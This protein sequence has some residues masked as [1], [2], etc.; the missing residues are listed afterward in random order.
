LFLAGHDFGEG[1][2][3]VIIDGNVNVFPADAA[4]VALLAPVVGDAVTDPVEPAQLFDVDV[5]HLTRALAFVAPRRLRW[6]ARRRPGEPQPP[7]HPAD[8]GFRDPNGGRDLLAG[9]ALPAQVRHR[10]AL[11]SGSLARRRVRP[12]RAISQPIDAFSLEAPDPF[13]DGLRRAVEPA[14][15]GSLAEPALQDGAHHLLST[16][17][18]QQGIL[19]SVHSVLRESLVLVDFSVHSLSRMDNL[20]KTHS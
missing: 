6:L 16:F 1:H 15:G 13:G 5:D 3:R 7:Q 11:G 2:A 9:V 10:L 17:R 12:G 8:R 4:M 14:R 18:G 19:V 20:L